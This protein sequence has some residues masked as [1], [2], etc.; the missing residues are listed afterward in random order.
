M[1]GLYKGDLV[2]FKD[3]LT[4]TK[5]DEMSKIRFGICGLQ[6][7]D[8]TIHIYRIIHRNPPYGI[9]CTEPI[10]VRVADIKKNFGKVEYNEFMRTHPEWI[11]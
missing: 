11:I 1:Q 5:D 8:S 6:I 2:R 3:Y 9:K 4:I 10:R 7:S